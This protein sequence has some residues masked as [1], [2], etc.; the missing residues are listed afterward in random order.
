LTYL[1]SW[2]VTEADNEIPVPHSIRKRVSLFPSG[3]QGYN[4]YQQR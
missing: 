2:V 1:I 4:L 3:S